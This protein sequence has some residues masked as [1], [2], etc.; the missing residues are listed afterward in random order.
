MPRYRIALAVAAFAAAPALAQEQGPTSAQAA[1]MNADGEQVG[2]AEFTSTPVGTLIR[3]ELTGLPPGPHGFHIH[4]TGACEAPTFESAGG[5][6]NP[7]DAEHGFLV[8]G[9]PHAGDMPNIHVPESG[10]LTI[11]VLNP[12][13]R[14]EGGELFDDDGSALMVHAGADD[15]QSQPSG[16]AGDRLVCGVIEPS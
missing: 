8:E 9:G 3:A 6:H 10:A 7:T 14:M 12:F 16:D 15:Y 5:H 4:E 13:V 11:E 2:T 1:L